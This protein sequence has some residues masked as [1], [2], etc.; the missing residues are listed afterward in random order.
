MENALPTQTRCPS[1]PINQILHLGS[2]PGYL[3][4]F[5]VLLRSV[6]KCGSSGGQNFDFSIDLAHPLYNSLLL[7]HKPWFIL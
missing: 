2:Y 3:S 1:S 6:E 4:W 5:Q 7:P